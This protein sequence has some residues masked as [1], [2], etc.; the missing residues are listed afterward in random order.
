MTHAAFTDVS[1]DA[2]HA[3][4]TFSRCSLHRPVPSTV[5]VWLVVSSTAP[6]NPSHLPPRHFSTELAQNVCLVSGANG[7][8]ELKW[9]QADSKLRGGGAALVLNRQ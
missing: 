9:D 4:L 5:S 2:T 7:I 1:A 8:F 3:T 6:P